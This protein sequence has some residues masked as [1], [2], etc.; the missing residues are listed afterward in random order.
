MKVLT[1][2]S[3]VWD[4]K[5]YQVLKKVRVICSHNSSA[6]D[7][8]FEKAF[9]TWESEYLRKKDAI[10][11]GRFVQDIPDGRLLDL[12]VQVHVS[13]IEEYYHS[14]LYEEARRKSV[15]AASMFASESV[16]MLGVSDG[17]EVY[18]DPVRV[19]VFSLDPILE[20]QF[21]NKVIEFLRELSRHGSEDDIQKV[22]RGVIPEGIKAIPEISE[23]TASVARFICEYEINGGAEL[24]RDICDSP[25]LARLVFLVTEPEYGFALRSLAGWTLSLQD[26]IGN[27][28][29]RGSH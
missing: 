7:P 19:G 12:A 18:V 3:D 14:E 25:D 4:E 24:V 16:R 6:S 11:L 9:Q 1:E 22:M 27:V 21:F 26:R 10:V 8:L 20:H 13:R 5:S 15:N 17:G 23:Y 28:S 29:D 2:K